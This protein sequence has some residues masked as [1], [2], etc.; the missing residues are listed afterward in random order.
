M[1]N[2]FINLWVENS[3]V[4]LYNLLWR[5]VVVV[6]LRTWTSFKKIRIVNKDVFEETADSRISDVFAKSI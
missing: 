5:M 3:E 6:V 4:E 1:Q 2:C